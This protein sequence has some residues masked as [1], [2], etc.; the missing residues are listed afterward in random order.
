MRGWSRGRHPSRCAQRRG[1]AAN[2]EVASPTGVRPS[3][4]LRRFFLGVV[5]PAWSLPGLVDWWCHRE[6]HIED[7][8]KGSVP[9]SLCHIAMLAEGGVALLLGLFA[10]PTPLA[11]GIMGSGAVVH[12]MTAAKDIAMATASEREITSFEQHVH[13]WLETLP[14]FAT[15]LIALEG[16]QAR[17]DKL[18]RRNP[19]PLTLRM[20]SDRPS[21]SYLAVVGGFAVVSAGVPHAEE[22]LRCVRGRSRR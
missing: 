11:V 22:L 13:A 18:N 2:K 9:E 4:V 21:A 5:V 19:G 1:S 12:Q 7:P 14:F 17:V 20:R 6:A 15:M 10:E 8:G 3:A 16:R